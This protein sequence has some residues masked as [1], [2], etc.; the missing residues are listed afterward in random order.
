MEPN[1]LFQAL[2][3][4]SDSGAIGCCVRARLQCM[5]AMVRETRAALKSPV[6][7]YSWMRLGCL[8][9]AVRREGGMSCLTAT[10]V[11]NVGKKNK[12]VGVP[13]IDFPLVLTVC[14]FASPKFI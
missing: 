11:R 5:D 12:F 8:D 14:W 3:A 6:V 7:E 9:A 2:G 10:V 1:S 4:T 13:D